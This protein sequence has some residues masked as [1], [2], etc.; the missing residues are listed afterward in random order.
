[1][2]GLCE[3]VT[4]SMYYSV[5]FLRTHD[6]VHY[7]EFNDFGDTSTFPPFRAADMRSWDGKTTE[8]F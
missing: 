8:N 7:L 2:Y 3:V 1:M 6:F 5:R 4:D